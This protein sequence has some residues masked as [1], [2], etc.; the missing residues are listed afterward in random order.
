[1]QS[2][3]HTKSSNQIEDELNQTAPTAETSPRHAVKQ[4]KKE[5][6]VWDALVLAD[7]N[8]F[9]KELERE[10]QARKKHFQDLQK[11]NIRHHNNRIRKEKEDQQI[12][13]A[14]GRDFA[15][16]AQKTILDE[17][18]EEQGMKQKKK[19]EAKESILMGVKEKQER[20]IVELAVEQD[21]LDRHFA[22]NIQ[23]ELAY[24]KREHAR[25]SEFKKAQS[26]N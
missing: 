16:R 6:A 7:Q 4:A 24:N 8:R 26:V 22:H 10:K 2:R 9:K 1:M 15:T 12:D 19:Q 21:E 14:E 3:L 17:T 13:V 23:Q 5:L 25:Q 20:R 11:F 18:K